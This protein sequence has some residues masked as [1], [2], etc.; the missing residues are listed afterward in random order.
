MIR[1]AVCGDNVFFEDIKSE[2]ATSSAYA[3]SGHAHDLDEFG[4]LSGYNSVFASDSFPNLGKLADLCMEEKVQLTVIPSGQRFIREIGE[5][6]VIERLIVSGMFGHRR[7]PA[8]EDGD[9][10]TG[11]KVLIT[12]AGGSIGSMLAKRVATYNPQ[13]L[14]IVDN[15]ENGIYMIDL[16]LAIS[17]FSNKTPIVMDMRDEERFMALVQEKR[18]D[19]LFHVAARKHVP[20]MEKF[21]EE[22]VSTNVEGTIIALKAVEKFGIKTFTFISTDKAADPAN[23]M[24]ASKKIAETV[25]QRFA[26]K[27]DGKFCIVRFENVLDSTGNVCYTFQRQL[28]TSGKLTVTSKDMNRYFITCDQASLF[29]LR[30]T[31]V[32]QK[33][34]VYVPVVGDPIYIDNLARKI[35]GVL[36]FMEGRDYQITYT[37]PREGEKMSE[38]L[39]THDE[40]KRSETFDG[41]IKVVPQ[42][43]GDQHF[44]ENLAKLLE[45]TKKFDR[46]LIVELMHRLE[47][48]YT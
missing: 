20:L 15:S 27:H 6:E 19:I 14:T 42:F 39:I 21:P 44:E 8:P 41:I 46:K 29:I 25:I 31:K 38:E 35:A 28:K 3:V 5:D 26:K 48:T 45:A 37:Q 23:V 10:I 33:A 40:E 2:L 1:V 18:P 7:N 22:A 30:A 12:G 17:G 9:Y 4:K 11:K 43:F 32:A 47:P 13:H 34:E 24:G 36:N 16:D